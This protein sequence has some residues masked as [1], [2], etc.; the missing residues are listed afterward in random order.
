MLPAR[1]QGVNNNIITGPGGRD[2]RDFM[3]I[4]RSI[5]YIYTHTYEAA[6][7]LLL[8][9]EAVFLIAKYHDARMA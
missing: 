8:L 3:D 6:S 2:T 7:S 4:Y 9:P 1:P 5:L